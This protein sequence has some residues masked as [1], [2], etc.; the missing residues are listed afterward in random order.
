MQEITSH[1]SSECA[2]CKHSLDFWNWIKNFA[3]AEADYVPPEPLVRLVKL[4]FAA[5]PGAEKDGWSLASL[6][7]D[8]VRQP[9]A[10]G[11]R[12]VAANTRQMVYEAEGLTVDLRFE[13]KPHSNTVFASGQ[14]LDQQAP[15]LWLGSSAVVLWNESGRTLHATY[16]N[17][18]GEF[19]LEFDVQEDLRIS[20]AT[21]GRRTLRIPLGSLE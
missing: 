18:H 21:A 1:L 16:T 14:V 5:Q 6:I 3:K 12:G 4:S 20:I 17:E 9:L 19:Q 10:M 11:V 15:L 13:R 7:Y 2:E 8:S